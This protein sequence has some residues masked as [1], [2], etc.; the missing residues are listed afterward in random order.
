MFADGVRRADGTAGQR[1]GMHNLVRSVI[2]ARRRDGQ[3][4]QCT[5][6]QRRDLAIIGHGFARHAGELSPS[7]GLQG[8][9]LRPRSRSRWRGSPSAEKAAKRK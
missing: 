5:V 7:W 3:L 6:T 1:R 8:C 9:S 4:E 2:G